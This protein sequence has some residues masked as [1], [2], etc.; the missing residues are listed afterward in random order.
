LYLVNGIYPLLSRFVL[1]TPDPSTKLDQ[2]FGKNQESFQKSI[3][4][5]FGILKKK[6]LMLS[7]GMRFYERDD[8]LYAAVNVQSFITV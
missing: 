3:E 5:A 2:H 8:T 1:T 6:F 4:W 7:S